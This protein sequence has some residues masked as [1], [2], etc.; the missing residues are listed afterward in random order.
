MQWQNFAEVK[1]CFPAVDKV[2]DTYVFDAGGNK[3]R[4]IAAIHF[5]TG[6]TKHQFTAGSSTGK[7]VQC[8]NRSVCGLN[9]LYN[10]SRSKYGCC[11]LALSGRF[12]GCWMS[13]KIMGLLG[14]T[15]LAVIGT[16]VV[17]IDWWG[18]HHPKK[19]KQHV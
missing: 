17:A 8:G 12:M 14:V 18:K 19:D 2:G 11:N 10:T 16:A 6:K 1:A 13:G 4:L 9:P 5:N 7:T 15:F 3:L